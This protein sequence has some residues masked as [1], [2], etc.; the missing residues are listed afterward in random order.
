MARASAAAST[1]SAS[2]AGRTASRSPSPVRSG[3]RSPSWGHPSGV[4]PVAERGETSTWK[5]CAARAADPAGDRVVGAGGALGHA[6]S[7]ARATPRAAPCRT[8]PRGRPGSRITRSGR[9]SG[10][11]AACALGMHVGGGPARRRAPT[12][13]TTNLFEGRVGHA[14][15]PRPRGPR[16]ERLER[17]A[18]VL[19][20]D[21]D[22]AALDHGLAAGRRTRRK[23]SAS[24]A[25]Q[26]AGVEPAVAQ[27]RRGRVRIGQ[28]AVHQVRRP[29]SRA[30]RPRRARSGAPSFVDD[31]DRAVD[32][33]AERAAAVGG[34][35]GPQ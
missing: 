11:S 8:A 31:P 26:V 6:Q 12:Q 2:A 24:H 27:H 7:P 18:D 14:D 4:G 9:R 16:L 22:A 28:V 25:E 13:T 15:R 5:I 23:P 30:A 19:R 20:V 35:G 10:A 1:P 32:R 34:V 33:L 3:R 17:P 21:G 29:P